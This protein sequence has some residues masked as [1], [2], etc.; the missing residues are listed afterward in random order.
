M[1]ELLNDID[2]KVMGPV[3]SAWG[4]KIGFA[5][6]TLFIGWKLSNWSGRLVCRALDKKGVDPTLGPF[7]SSL[8]SM[9]IKIAV[10][11]SAI[12]TAGI[13]A[14]SFA[15]IV[16][17]AGLAVGM[18]LSGTLQNFSGGV[19]LLIIRPFRVGDVIEAQGY[20]GKVRGIQ[21]F[22]TILLTGDNRM[23]HIP[24]GKLSNESLIN[25]STMP[26][27]RVD[28]TFGISYDDR[29]DHARDVIMG[30][31]SQLEQVHETP[32]PFVKVSTLG[33]SSV[34]IAVRVWVDSADYWGVHFSL[35]EQVKEAFDEAGISMPFPQ[36]NVIIHQ[37]KEI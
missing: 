17:A 8:V 14:T 33:A 31:I 10:V 25:Y 15:A 28:A 34:D 30:V 5:L 20:V 21:I 36:R 19:I 16:G 37:A 4:F 11:V 12:Q 24:N 3:V 32:A 22:Q 1:Q 26:T 27:R 9:V 7:L 2:W 13:Q 6:L 23:I 29:I 18:A 35:N